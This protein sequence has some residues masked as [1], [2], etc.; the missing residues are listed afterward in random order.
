MNK[1][2]KQDM[3]LDIL[4]DTVTFYGEDPKERR[5]I[6]YE[7]DCQYTWG[8]N[9]CAI[10]RYLKPKYQIETW[11]DNG[12]SVRG[13]MD[14][15]ED[16]SEIDWCLKDEVHGVDVEFWID[17]QILHDSRLNWDYKDSGLSTHGQEQYNKMIR[18][19]KDDMYE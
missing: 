15:S 1:E 4:E 18:L 16:F 11:R 2:Q 7:G 19:I 3:M 12:E 10:G 5:C 6:T 8:D 14:C 17:L 9:H 13:L